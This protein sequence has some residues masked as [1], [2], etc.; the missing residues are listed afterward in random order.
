MRDYLAKM[1]ASPYQGA[2]PSEIPPRSLAPWAEDVRPRGRSLPRRPPVLHVARPYGHG[3]RNPRSGR[4]A[5]RGAEGHIG[6]APVQGPNCGPR[7]SATLHRPAQ[8]PEQLVA[9]G[10]A[11]IDLDGGGPDRFID[12]TFAW[13]TVEAIEARIQAHLDAGADHVCIQPIKADGQFGDLDWEA[14]RR[15]R[16]LDQ[17]PLV[18]NSGSRSRGVGPSGPSYVASRWTLPNTPLHPTLP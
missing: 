13:G 18:P 16:L 2:P 17:P 5:L 14:L 15:W 11:R 12:A 3:A 6:A 8:L 10:P 7:R 4:E 9:H 1:A